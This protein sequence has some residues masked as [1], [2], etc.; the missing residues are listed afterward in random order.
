MYLKMIVHLAWKNIWRNPVRSGVVLAA[1]AIGIWSLMFILSFSSGMIA[2]YIASAIESRTSHIQIHHPEFI[3]DP[4]I[5]HFLGN[6]Q[7]F[8]TKLTQV[9]KVN[10]WAFRL[11]S[12]GLASSAAG[13]RGVQ[14]KGIQPEE[15]AILTKL[16]EKIIEG[17]YL[18]SDS[19]NPLLIS[20]G[21]SRNLG[22]QI[23]QHIVLS[24]QGMEEDF[25]SGRFRISGYFDTGNTRADDMVVY[26]RYED[27]L[28]VSGMSPDNFH[29]VAIL[30]EDIALVDEVRSQLSDILPRTTVRTFKEISPDLAIYNEQISAMLAIVIVVIMIALLFGIINTMLMAV[31]ERQRELGMLM[32]IGMNRIK[33]FILIMTEAFILCIIAAPVGVLFGHSTIL[34]LKDKG[35]DLS[36]W[37]SGFEEFGLQPI[38]RPELE[39]NVYVDIVLALVITAIVAGIYPAIKAV[40]TKPVE[41]LRKV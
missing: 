8:D 35:L 36:N 41:A 39:L 24:F 33:I 11:M 14:I 19:R 29:E 3:D 28:N 25:V 15:E 13:N 9:T 18:D 27:F 2:S 17:S 31:L 16:S 23:G 30:L 22:V 26:V 6:K 20:K 10:H 1:V 5:A 21:L 37:A 4:E 12:T 32:A 40:R 7:D 38:I 34:L